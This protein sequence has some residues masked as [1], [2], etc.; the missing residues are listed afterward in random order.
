MLG[1]RPAGDTNGIVDTAERKISINYNKFR[2]KSDKKTH[3]FLLN[4]TQ[5][6]CPKGLIMLNLKYYHLSF[7]LMA[8]LL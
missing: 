2:F 7:Q 5:E 1:E 4:I 8:M 3:F 6:A